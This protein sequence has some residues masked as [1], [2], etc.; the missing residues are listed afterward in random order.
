MLLDVHFFMS[1]RSLHHRAGKLGGG[2]SG[3]VYSSVWRR[4]QPV[5]VKVLSADVSL[6]AD[7]LERELRIQQ[8]IQA[9]VRAHSSDAYAGWRADKLFLKPCYGSTPNIT[10]IRMLVS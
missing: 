6:P 7:R 8:A 3:I 9:Q 2:G 5:A 1:L 10:A 4:S